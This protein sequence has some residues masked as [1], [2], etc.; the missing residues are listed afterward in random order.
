[1]E[2]GDIAAWVGIAITMAISLIARR[3]TKRQAQ[4]AEEA[5]VASQ[6][7]VE[8][9]E[10]RAIAV[11]DNLT[12]ALRLLAQSQQGS[13]PSPL[14][15][16]ARRETEGV[17]WTLERRGK[18]SYVLRN[19]GTATASGVH[20]DR[21][22]TTPIVRNLPDNATVRPG[23]SVQFLMAPTFGNPLPGE[24]WVEW[25]GHPPLAVPLPG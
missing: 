16:P 18:H 14:P 10:R 13:Q 1:M 12:E 19:V 25:D 5:N 24:V 9:T 15:A 20:V 17:R 3:D 4:I 21:N 7:Q 11:E 8:A 2:P 6:A 22:R 23:E